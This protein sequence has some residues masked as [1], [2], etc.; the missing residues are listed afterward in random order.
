LINYSFNSKGDI[1]IIDKYHTVVYNIVGKSNFNK[2]VKMS[3]ITPD[4]AH[5]LQ[6]IEET[7]SKKCANPNGFWANKIRGREVVRRALGHNINPIDL[8]EKMWRR[9]KSQQQ[10]LH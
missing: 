5:I 10:T 9:R 8:A 7:V 1:F 2:G 6:A 3:E 4:E